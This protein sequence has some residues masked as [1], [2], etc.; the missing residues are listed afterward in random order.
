MAAINA[1]SPLTAQTLRS[2]L[3]RLSSDLDISTGAL[4]ITPHK[5]RH[6]AATRF[7]EAGVDI[8][9]VQKLLGHA[10]ITTTEIYAGVSDETLRSQM[11]CAVGHVE[12][13]IINKNSDN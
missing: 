12:G 5:F 13:G 9:L 1:G 10:S 2:R 8:R 6:M 11:E 7:L 3:K 4:R